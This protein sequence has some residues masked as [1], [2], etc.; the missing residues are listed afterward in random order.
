LVGSRIELAKRN[1]GFGQASGCGATVIRLAARVIELRLSKSF[2][3]ERRPDAG[4]HK[5]EFDMHMN[6]DQ[7]KGCLKVAEG[8]LKERA[9]AITGDETLESNGQNERYLGEAQAKFGDIKQQQKEAKK[10]R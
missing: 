2:R 3:S 7:I 9:A 4:A 10:T 6:K 1:F 8:K 5:Q